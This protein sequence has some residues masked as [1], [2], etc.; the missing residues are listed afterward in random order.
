MMDLVG[1]LLVATPEIND[2]YFD[3]AV[4]YICEHTEQGTMGLMLNSPTDLS[5]MELLAKMDFLMANSRNYIEDQLVLSGGPVNQDR[6]FI[7][8]TATTTPLA[9]SYP[10]ENNLWLTTSGDILETL[11]RS[12]S[13]KHFVVCLGCCTWRP[14]QLEQEIGQND[15]LVAPYDLQT[16]FETGYLDRWVKANELLGIEGVL[17]KAGRA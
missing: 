11:G 6:G 16:I 8:H 15:W 7:L 2:D 3:R 5:V 4:I 10:T 17:A 1:K 13:P 12:D 9:H 14:Q